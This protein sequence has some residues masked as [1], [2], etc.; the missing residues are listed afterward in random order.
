M[1]N[2]MVRD[3]ALVAIVAL[4][5][6]A[7]LRATAGSIL[8]ALR[9]TSLIARAVIVNVIVMPLLA[10]AIVRAFSLAQPIAIGVV[11]MALAPGVP[12]LTRSA[13]T[14]KGGNQPFAI[15]LSLV[16]PAISVVTLPL[17]VGILAPAIV[18]LH[19]P[20]GRS[21]ATI[22]AAQ[23]LPLLA[24]IAIGRRSERLRTAL[25]GPV[26][27]VSVVALVAVAA[28]IAAPGVKALASLF[29]TRGLS[30]ILLLEVLGLAI[31]WWLGGPG[32]D[33]RHTLAIATVLRNVGLAAALAATVF[34]DTGVIAAVMAFLII[35]LLVSTI[36]GAFFSRGSAAALPPAARPAH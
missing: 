26:A 32:S 30:A 20:V 5:F 35:Q 22:L 1:V 31:G 36:A 18:G 15:T 21:V 2:A 11:L 33:T 34:P 7:G 6:L 13:G 9:N 27:I 25:V 24:G 12:F 3:F 28:L 29:G 19:M 10:V 8:A 14:Q 16:L 17:W 4:M 23:L